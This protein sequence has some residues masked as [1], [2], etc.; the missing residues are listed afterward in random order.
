MIT[1]GSE[2]YRARQALGWTAQ[3]MGE[4]LRF[5]SNQNTRVADI[6]SGQRPLSGSVAVAVELAL[7]FQTKGIDART[8]K[9]HAPA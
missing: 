6:E 1:T 5:R 8:I 7:A 4:F 3:E 2:L 9:V